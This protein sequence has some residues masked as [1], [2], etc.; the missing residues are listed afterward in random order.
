MR[1]FKDIE[2]EKTKYEEKSVKIIIKEKEENMK[3]SSN[4]ERKDKNLRGRKQNIRINDTEV[5]R[6]R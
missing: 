1:F 2:L 4:R 5:R 3:N 6:R